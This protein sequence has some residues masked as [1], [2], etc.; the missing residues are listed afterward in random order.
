MCGHIQFRAR[1]EGAALEVARYPSKPSVLPV[2]PPL[3][4]SPPLTSRSWSVPADL[5]MAGTGVGR[6]YAT[7]PTSKQGVREK[8]WCGGTENIL[9]SRTPIGLG[10]PTRGGDST[11]ISRP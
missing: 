6:V 5:F 8:R 7:G 2:P 9:Q 1:W 10:A 11:P 4:L 3:S